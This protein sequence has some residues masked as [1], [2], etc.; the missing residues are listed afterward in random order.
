MQRVAVTGATGHLGSVLTRK[1]LARGYSVR[2]IVRDL[3]E[4]SE[5]ALHA[6]PSE[7]CRDWH[8]ADGS[9]SQWNDR[10]SA[11]HAVP[12]SPCRY[13]SGEHGNVHSH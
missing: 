4:V 13:S 2:A 8:A 9:S 12:A 7:W 1:L 6:V 11:L 3:Q 5:E 10:E